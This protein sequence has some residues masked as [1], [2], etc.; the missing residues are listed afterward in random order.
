MGKLNC[1]PGDLAIIVEAYNPINI[2]AVV[3]VLRR[4][5]NQNAVCAPA[6]DY[7]WLIEAPHPLTYEIGDKLV[8]KR[9]GGAPDSSL[10]PIRGLPLGK[11]IADGV[12]DLYEAQVGGLA[13]F[14]VNDSGT[15][16]DPS[17]AEPRI[18]AD[19]FEF[20]KYDTVESLISTIERYPPLL[21]SFQQL[22]SDRSTELSA[23][24]DADSKLQSALEDMDFGW[25]EWIRYEGE[26][27][28]NWFVTYIDETWLQQSVDWKDVDS[29]PP[30]CSGVGVAKHYFEQ[31]DGKT[32]DALGIDIIEGEHPASTYYA[33]ELKYD[34]DYANQRAR[35]LGL[36]FRFKTLSS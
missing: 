29:F 30:H 21:Y 13:V 9:K 27:G 2:G 4:H 33:A 5:K 25:K 8:R 11:D 10:R 28:M 32:L 23:D 22:A 34:V 15:I 26:G 19:I 20:D 35:G 3:R 14:H 7:I 6:G 18:N 1:R 17:V 36:D 16:S 31:L 24:D 12:R